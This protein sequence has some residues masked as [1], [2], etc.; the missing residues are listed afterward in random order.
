NTGCY[1][2]EHDV[3][4]AL[5]G[6][7]VECTRSQNTEF[8][9]RLAAYCRENGLEYGV[10]DL[11]LIRGNR[12]PRLDGYYRGKHTGAT[13]IL[14]RHGYTLRENPDEMA[15]Y[16]AVA[17]VNAARMG[18]MN[19]ARRQLVSAIRIHP[20]KMRNYFRLGLTLVPGLARRIWT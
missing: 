8:A 4:Q 16:H 7:E 5:G 9:L 6:Y 19:E 12:H 15:T 10:V 2:V 20:T 11:P 17:G 14:E 13:F 18:S 1:A 3:F